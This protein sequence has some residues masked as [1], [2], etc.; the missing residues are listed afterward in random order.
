MWTGTDPDYFHLDTTAAKDIERRLPQ[1]GVG[2]PGMG[3]TGRLDGDR[4][5]P[6]PFGKVMVQP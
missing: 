3:N 4:L 6:A 5:E 1:L 2:G